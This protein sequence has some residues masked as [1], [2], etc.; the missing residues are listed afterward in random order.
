MLIAQGK[1]EDYLR[2]VGDVLASLK[3]ISG[4]DFGVAWTD[5]EEWLKNKDLKKDTAKTVLPTYYEM[6]VFSDH[7]VFIIDIS[8]SMEAKG[9]VAVGEEPKSQQMRI[10][11][12]KSEMRKVI[13]ALPAATQFNIISGILWIRN[14]LLMMRHLLKNIKT[15]LMRHMRMWIR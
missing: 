8:G 13:Q 10:D 14:I 15:Q 11:V 7:V 3:T 1:Q 4:R 6:T 12:A 9:D 2:V 5:W